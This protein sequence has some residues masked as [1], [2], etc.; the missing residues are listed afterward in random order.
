MLRRETETIQ[1]TFADEARAMRAIPEDH[2]LLRMR[3]AIDWGA[4][5]AELAP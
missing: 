1:R 2:G 4:V 3:R 5:E